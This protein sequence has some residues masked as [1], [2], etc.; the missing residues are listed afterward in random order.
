M[1]LNRNLVQ[2]CA[3]IREYSRLN[4]PILSITIPYF[5]LAECYMLVA[6]LYGDPPFTPSVS[7]EFPSA[8]P[9]CTS[10]F[11]NVRRL[12]STIGRL[13]RRL[14]D[15]IRPRFGGKNE[16][17]VLMYSK[18]KVFMAH[19]FAA[20]GRLR[21]YVF[22]IFS[23]YRITSKTYNAIFVYTSSFFMYIF[24]K[25]NAPTV[26]ISLCNHAALLYGQFAPIQKE[27]KTESSS[28]QQNNAEKNKLKNNNNQQN[29]VNK[30]LHF[31]FV[32]FILLIT[33]YLGTFHLPEEHQFTLESFSTN[34]EVFSHQMVP[35]ALWTTFD[36]AISLSVFSTILIL[37]YAALRED[38]NS[39][40]RIVKNAH[41]QYRLGDT[42][43]EAEVSSKIRHFQSRLSYVIWFCISFF[44]LLAMVF[45]SVNVLLLS[46]QFRLSCW[47]ILFWTTLFS[48]FLFY[49]FYALL[50]FQMYIIGSSRII[51]IRQQQLLSPPAKASLCP[52]T[53][54]SQ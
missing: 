54:E 36:L 12:S 35:R 26:Q 21:P 1:R 25:Q 31:T 45:Y 37:I 42:L 20:A 11:E 4:S 44:Y 18:I 33:S 24:K 53:D 8:T 43:L 38:L 50:G 47:S 23:N 39:Q 49:N 32:I 46:G 22:C 19:R 16:N 6:V 10:T 3:H 40:F 5:M 34:P 14:G 17:E 52:E 41:G 27:V 51:R 7:P 9:S 13:R 29:E 15:F 2:L 48:P 30:K 28:D